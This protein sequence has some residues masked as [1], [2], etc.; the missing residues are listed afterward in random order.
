MSS[1]NKE[2][3]AAEIKRA[4][5]LIKRFS[6][7]KYAGLNK[8]T[9]AG[10]YHLFSM[11]QSLMEFCEI[12]EGESTITK[13]E[14]IMRVLALIEDPFL[15]WTIE[16]LNSEKIGYEPEIQQPPV[17]ELTPGIMTALGVL[18]K[19]QEPEQFAPVV[20]FARANT[21]MFMIREKEFFQHPTGLED[22]FQWSPDFQKKFVLPYVPV[23]VDMSP[24][25]RDFLKHMGAFYDANK[26]K[27]DVERWRKSR[28]EYNTNMWAEHLLLAFIDLQMACDVYGVDCKYPKAIAHFLPQYEAPEKL[29]PIIRRQTLS[30]M[31][32]DT[33]Y[34]LAEM[35]TLEHRT[36]PR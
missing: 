30:L 11:R 22:P 31:H 24:P 25:K 19:T 21:Q 17:K 18:M 3:K 6:P 35:A 12:G 14:A 33:C 15:G 8:L 16:E 13:S 20:E 7:D 34:H 26:S 5:D 9:T 2:T 36:K 28:K 4:L 27:Y 23:L 10:W 29:L 32:P 1:N